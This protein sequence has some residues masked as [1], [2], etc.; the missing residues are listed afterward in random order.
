LQV[1]KSTQ[2]E[3]EGDRRAT[4]VY[5][6]E[7]LTKKRTVQDVRADAGGSE[8]PRGTIQV[9]GDGL[10]CKKNV[11]KGYVVPG[12]HTYGLYDS[13]VSGWAYCVYCVV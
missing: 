10:L 2:P 7:V 12:G 11:T 4:Y 1:E 9:G 13:T 5:T 8:F 3:S 6:M